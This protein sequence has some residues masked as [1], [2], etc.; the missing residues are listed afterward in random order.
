MIPSATRPARRRGIEILDDPNVDPA[1]VTRS[2]GDVARANRL[3][4]GTRAA[5]AEMS[6]C[7]A[8]LPASATL[9]DV[10]TGS[11]DI[12]TSARV[13]CR[14]AG[15]TLTTF[16]LDTAEELATLSRRNHDVTVCANGLALPLADRSVDVVM[17]SQLLHHFAGA[18]ALQ[19]LKEMN[20]VARKRVVVSDLRRSRT[21]ALGLW[22]ASFPLRFHP[23]SRHDG[24]VSVMRGFTPFELAETVRAALGVSPTV[25]RRPGFRITTS[26]SPV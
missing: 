8:E 9:L 21:A 19:L 14:K 2:L 24:V 25:T 11:G 6:R 7:I 10:G 15:I 4:G 5:V 22:I 16:G 13:R 1:L 12:P 3:F 17:C 26:W 20:R 18:D 23:V